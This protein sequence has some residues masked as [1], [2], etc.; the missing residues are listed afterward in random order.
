MGSRNY[1]MRAASPCLFVKHCLETAH[2]KAPILRRDL[3]T[4]QKQCFLPFLA[5]NAIPLQRLNRFCRVCTVYPN[6]GRAS[7]SARTNETRTVSVVQGPVSTA[8][9]QN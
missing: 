6:L 7:H 5:S 8:R 4:G 3:S 1:E 9:T 2:S